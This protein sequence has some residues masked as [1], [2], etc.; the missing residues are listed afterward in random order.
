MIG[1]RREDKNIWE[2]RVPLIPEDAKQL[3]EKYGIKII[4]QP[5]DN[6]AF[7]NDS[8]VA[9]GCEINENIDRSDLIIAVK[10]IPESLLSQDKTYVYFSHTIKGQSYNMSML[11]RLMA[12]KCNL[13]DYERI[14]DEK[15][16]RLIFFGRY[17]GYAGMIETLHALGK[18]LELQG[19]TN[20]LSEIHQAY[21][22]NCVQD[23]K[24]H[25]RE[26]GKKITDLGLE[27]PGIVGFAGYGN[28]SQA[29][30][31]IFDLL[32]H[33]EI[34]PAELKTIDRQASA[35]KYFLYKVV[36]KESDMV[37][38]VNGE[39][40][41]QDYYDHPENYR[42]KFKE[43]LP[44]LTVL[45]NCIYWTEAYPRL[46]TMDYL[47]ANPDLGLS[48]IGDI[49]VDIEGSIQATYKATYPDKA[50][51]TFDANTLE[52]TD[53]ITSAGLTIMAI[54]NLPCEFP[55]ESSA[56]F[57]HVLKDL[58]PDIL[59]ADFQLPAEEL[60]LPNSIKKALILHQG[61]LTADY[62]YMNQYLTTEK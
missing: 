34:T 56:A 28:V 38:P 19:I 47:K 58:L 13:I 25:I 37:E 6:R 29:A 43:Y 27:S 8:F 21:E 50:C 62:R 40:I 23:A 53:G 61:E 22:Y 20:P 16:R 7:S 49:S 4:V 15:N 2:R 11:R 42:S 45:V 46:I 57:S 55:K 35:E 18:K 41:L 32:P 24:D 9:A 39:F 12:L 26:I 30:Q 31:E 14:V 33:K 44:H 17:A 60:E 59:K 51:Y 1:V 48:V 5:S 54:D 52:Y 10:E 36:F 3:G